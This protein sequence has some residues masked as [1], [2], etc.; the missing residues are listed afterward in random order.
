M[1]T[2][3]E[4]PGGTT[5]GQGPE[6]RIWDG[7]EPSAFNEHASLVGPSIKI[8][9]LLRLLCVTALSVSGYL[10]YAGLTG[11]KIAGC[12]GGLWD[13]DHVTST[14]WGKWFGMPVG[15]AAC[16]MY[17]VCT[18]SLCFTGTRNERLRTA[19]WKLLTVAGI[20][21]GLA[22]VWF[23]SLQVIVIGHLCKWCL[24]AHGCG[25]AVC[26]LIL[27]HRPAPS[28]TQLSILSVLGVGVLV[29]GQLA[30]KPQTYE[31]EVFPDP[32]TEGAALLPPG[33]DDDSGELE[34]LAPPVPGMDDSVME[35]PAPPPEFAPPI[36]GEGSDE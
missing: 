30:Y 25:L 20:A 10:A 28:T 34:I 5:S 7:R 8:I 12:G 23:I 9:W 21:A 17:A 13:C 32:A 15:L 14:R 27:W 19:V 16:G 33:M 24:V 31:E 26:G 18:G 1:I 2:T 35:A 11:S 36:I 22:A 29:G 6:L 3:Q 4:L